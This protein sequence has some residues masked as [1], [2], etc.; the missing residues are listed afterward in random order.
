[1]LEF[2]EQHF[3]SQRLLDVFLDNPG[4]RT[5][6]HALVVT[7]VSKPGDCAFGQFEGH[8][9]LSKLSF[10]LK[11]KLLHNLMNDGNRQ[12]TERNDRIQSVT[13]LRREQAVD[14]FHVIAFATRGT[15]ADCCLRHIRR[16]GIGGHDQDHIAEVDLLAV[17]IG[18][19]AMIHHLQQNVEQIRMRLL[20]FIEQQHAMRMLIDAIGQESA[21]IEAN[22][23]GRRTDEP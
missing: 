10:K 9:A 18:Q 11:H 13:E 19:R 3:I 4:K 7:L 8:A 17:V 6:T 22:I 23:A 20:D 14:R 2:S 5:C 15:E 16:T 12:R 21:L 1:M